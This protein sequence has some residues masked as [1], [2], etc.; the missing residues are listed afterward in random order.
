MGMTGDEPVTFLRDNCWDNVSVPDFSG[1]KALIVS[2]SYGEPL[3]TGEATGLT[4]Q[5]LTAPYYVYLDAGMDVDVCSLQ[6][7]EI[8]LDGHETPTESQLRAKRD[9]VLQSKLEDSL[10]LDDVDFQDYAVV[11]MAGGWGAAFDL[12][13]SAVLGGKVAA[14]LEAG[15]PLVGSVCHGALGFIMANKTD[16]TPWLQ[17]MK[18]TGVTNDQLLYFNVT[19]QTPMHPEDELIKKGADYHYIGGDGPLS[20]VA[21][22]CTVIDT[23][24]PIVVTGQNQNSGCVAAQ[25]QL[26]VLASAL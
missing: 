8:P 21:A 5:E 4:L 3:S 15:T 18:A 22:T 7:G 14:A 2:T 13:Y 16:G 9:S 20:D 17:G 26:Q 12:G 11:M 23:Q 10:L 6:G 24:G 1:R 25:R 19:Y